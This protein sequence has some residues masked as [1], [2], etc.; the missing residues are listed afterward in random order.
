MLVRNFLIQYLG[1]VA[2]YVQPHMLDRF[3][4]RDRFDQGVVARMK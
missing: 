3:R 4:D 1:D 2:A